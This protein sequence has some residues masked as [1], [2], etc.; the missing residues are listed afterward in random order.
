MKCMRASVPKFGNWENED[1]VPYTVYFDKARKTRG[2]VMINPNDPQE[3]PDMFPNVDSSPLTPSRAPA[4][5]SR[6]RNRPPEDPIGRSPAR[7]TNEQRVNR[8]DGYSNSPARSS[9]NMVPR[10]GNESSYGGGRGQRPA[11][12]SPRA[13]AGSE[14]SFERSPIHQHYQDKVTAASGRGG[15]GS[16]AW[17]GR[18]HD[19]SHGTGGG[20]SRL[21]PVNRGDGSPD[22]GAAVPRFGDWEN[23]PESAENFTQIFNQVRD[24]KN[25]GTGNVSGTPKHPSY[26]PRGQQPNEPK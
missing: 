18:N 8:E 2:G 12:R 3:N 24:E 15:S 22:K 13:S 10:S 11:G 26:G 7:P 16:P 9:E 1:D 23:D 25:T 21:R 17:D 14:Q 20:K 4:T 5:P 6:S 19:S